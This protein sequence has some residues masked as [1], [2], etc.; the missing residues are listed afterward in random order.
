MPPGRHQVRGIQAAP[1]HEH[2]QPGHV[3]YVYSPPPRVTLQV[4]RV[5]RVDGVHLPNG[6]ALMGGGEAMGGG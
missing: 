6:A 2:V 5:L 3:T 4:L 1:A